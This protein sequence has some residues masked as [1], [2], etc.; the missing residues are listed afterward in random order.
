MKITL[1]IVEHCDVSTKP[2]YTG[3]N[4][5]SKDLF[6]PVSIKTVIKANKI[7]LILI[8]VFSLVL[9]YR[10]N[11]DLLLY[12]VRV[13]IWCYTIISCFI[14]RLGLQTFLVTVQLKLVVNAINGSVELIQNYI[15]CGF[16]LFKARASRRA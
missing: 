13:P 16:T 4:C 8:E 10:S 11:N 3:F 15:Y 6:V 9:A 12:F 7:I 14:Y 5:L 1:L 2:E